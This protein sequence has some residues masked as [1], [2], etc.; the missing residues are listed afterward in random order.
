M[1]RC[2]HENQRPSG[3]IDGWHYCPD[4]GRFALGQHEKKEDA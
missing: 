3:Y 2:G 4:C 1:A